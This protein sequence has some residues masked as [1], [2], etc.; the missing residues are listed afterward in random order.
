MGPTGPQGG[1]SE[2]MFLYRES[3][4]S[5]M[6]PAEE[7]ELIVAKQRSGPCETIGLHIT[8]SSKRISDVEMQQNGRGYANSDSYGGSAF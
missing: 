2:G 7:G 1:I 4:Y 3:L 5:P 8:A 6:V